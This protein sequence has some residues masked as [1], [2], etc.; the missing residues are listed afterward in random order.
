MWKKAMSD[1]YYVSG[2]ELTFVD[3]FA[4]GPNNVL[5]IGSKD[6][7]KLPPLP[8]TYVYTQSA[9]A[10]Q[11][12]QVYVCAS[13]RKSNNLAAIFFKFADGTWRKNPD[14]TVDGK[15]C[16]FNGAVTYCYLPNSFYLP[17][18]T[19]ELPGRLKGLSF[20]RK[21]DM[22]D[23]WIPALSVSVWYDT[24]PC[25]K[26]AIPVPLVSG[27]T[28]ILDAGPSYLDLTSFMTTIYASS[29]GT[30]YAFSLVDPVTGLPPSPVVPWIG[31]S[32]AN[33]IG[34]STDSAI[35]G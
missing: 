7:A 29:C 5:L 25:S 26:A 4:A 30:N 3:E 35:I 34:E 11:I 14:L 19:T 20:V 9:L 6:N 2:I 27:M 21:K 16:D 23:W 31:F 12:V 32:G 22:S 18:A 13:R 15:C 24:D 8:Y 28:I 33:M 10:E 1:D 17:S